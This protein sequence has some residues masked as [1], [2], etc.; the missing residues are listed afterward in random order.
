MVSGAFSVSYAVLCRRHAF[1]IRCGHNVLCIDYNRL[2]RLDQRKLCLLRGRLLAILLGC[3][4]GGELP[5][6]EC[7]GVSDDE[8]W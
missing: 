3:V 6:I 2:L 5:R 7:A 1:L 8:L 4:A